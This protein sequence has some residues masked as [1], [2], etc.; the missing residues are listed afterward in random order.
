MKKTNALMV[1]FLLLAVSMPVF[2]DCMMGWFCKD[3]FHRAYRDCNCNWLQTE[4]C[5]YGCINGTCTPKPNSA[6]TIP[7]VSITP[8]PATTNNDLVCRAYSTDPDNDPIEYEYKWYRN[9]E[10]YSTRISSSQTNVLQAT[11]TS[12]GETWMCKVRAYDQKTYSNYGYYEITISSGQQCTPGWK[13]KDCCTRAYQNA[14]CSWSNEE[15]CI[16]GCLNGFC[17]GST[18]NRPPSTPNVYISPSSPVNSDDLVCYA[19]STDP[20]NDSIEYHYTWKRNGST[21]RSYS[22]QNNTTTISNSF[23][24][25][26][27][28]WQCTVRAFDGQNYSDFSFDTVKIGSSSSGCGFSV[29]LYPEYNSIRMQRN[30][31]RNIRVKIENNSCNYYCLNLYGRE[32]SSYIDATASTNYVC[33][34]PG[35]STWVSL[36]IQTIDAPSGNYTAKLEAQSGG[37]KESA[38]ISIKVESCTTCGSCTSG[39]CLYIS[40]TTKALCRGETGTL[41][42]LVRNNSSEIKEV[43]LEASSTEFLAYFEEST[44]EVDARSEK[45]VPL[46]TYVYPGTSLGSYYVNVS[47]RTDQEYAQTKAYFTVKDCEEPDTQ[48]FTLSLSGTCVSLEKGKDKNISFTVKNNTSNNLTVNLQTIADIP[49]EVQGSVDL[50][51][52]ETKTLRLNASARLDEATGKHYVK[53]YAWTAKHREYKTA[54]FDVEKRR[55]SVFSVKDRNTTIEQCSNAV[56]SLLIENQGDYNESYSIE[57][58]NSTKAKITLSEKS[59]TLAPGKG[60]EVFINVDAPMDLKEGTYWFDVLVKGSETFSKRI[61]FSVVKAREKVQAEIEIAAYPSTIIIFPGETKKVSV[62]LANRSSE[63]ISGIK[64]NWSMP[65]GT[66]IQNAIVDLEAKEVAAFEFNAWASE[67]IAPENYYG[68]LSVEFDGRKISKNITIAVVSPQQPVPAESEGKSS[69]A[70]QGF[71]PLSALAALGK[72]LGIGLII[73]LIIVIVMIALKGFIES[74]TN[75]SKPVWHRR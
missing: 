30:D 61:Y 65:Q 11:H 32:Y 24:E 52:N 64:I 67:E 1:L 28:E 25:Y 68:T 34:N 33:L 35:E 22:T 31:A 29:R 2:A 53:L 9:S 43:E 40:S 15:A 18:Q 46:K 59:F 6:P 69:E 8:N 45:Y 70:T 48:S 56:F 74:D 50:N 41:S 63:K 47:A 36:S 13:C 51:P 26:G 5:P 37:N 23:T 17:I 27:D 72:P 49:T 60:R 58:S 42:I 14:D 4:Y 12:P 44:I 19:H 21:F 71:W 38:S 75:H 55:K 16:N 57:I 20:D 10:Y 73:L 62:A 66:S 54:C 39:S 3:A 7:E